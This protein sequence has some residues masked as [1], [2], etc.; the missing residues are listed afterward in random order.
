[1]AAVFIQMPP[2]NLLMAG[3]ELVLAKK[4]GR[5]SLGDT[6]GQVL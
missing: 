1:M 4:K 2:R 5:L 6:M 3:H